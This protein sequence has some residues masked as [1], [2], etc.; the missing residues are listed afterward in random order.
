MPGALIETSDFMP[1]SKAR[2]AIDRAARAGRVGPD[3]F[4]SVESFQDSLVRIGHFSVTSC[5]HNLDEKAKRHNAAISGVTELYGA[6]HRT[7]ILITFPGFFERTLAT[8]RRREPRVIRH[9]T[10]Y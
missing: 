1:E 6:L 3:T 4:Q 8:I 9:L 10:I 7:S 5:K 2:E